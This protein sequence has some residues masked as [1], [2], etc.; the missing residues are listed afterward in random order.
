MD[1]FIYLFIYLFETAFCLHGLQAQF[2]SSSV[3]LL[4]K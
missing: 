3:A 2:V 1:L 4:N